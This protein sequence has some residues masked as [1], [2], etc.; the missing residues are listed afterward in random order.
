MLK[1]KCVL[2][3]VLVLSM[4]LTFTA[5]R[6]KKPAPSPTNT[7]TVPAA[8][9]ISGSCGENL[10]FSLDE[11]GVLTIS[12]TGSMSRFDYDDGEVASPWFAQREAIVKVVMQDGISGISAHA[13]Y[14]CKNLKEVVIPDGTETI[15]ANAFMDCT[16]LEKITIPASVTTMEPD[17]F[18]GCENVTV[19]AP[20]GSMA[21]A[22]AAANN[23]KVT[24]A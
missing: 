6:E 24:A 22:Y 20:A 3:I 17:I 23:L 19:V 21:Y 16:A 4:L 18:K 15:K 11:N 2:S 12:G 7:S 8:T 1:H 14:K 5:C 13:F 9:P 10:T